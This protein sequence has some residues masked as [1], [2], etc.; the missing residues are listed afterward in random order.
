VFDATHVFGADLNCLDCAEAWPCPGYQDLVCSVFD[1]DMDLVAEFMRFFLPDANRV[2]GGL[3]QGA[4]Q[5]RV[6]GWC[7]KRR[8]RP[9]V[10]GSPRPRAGALLTARSSRSLVA[11]KGAA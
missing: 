1:D 2:L 3:S 9:A 5:E 10:L 8:L 11:A 6:V 4:V 7:E